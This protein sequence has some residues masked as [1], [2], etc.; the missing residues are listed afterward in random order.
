M[1]IL[2]GRIGDGTLGE[3]GLS[4]LPGIDCTFYRRK[5]GSEVGRFGCIGRSKVG[6]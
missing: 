6:A 1:G 4:N 3:A 5:G 2:R